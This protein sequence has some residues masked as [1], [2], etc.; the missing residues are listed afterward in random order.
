MVRGI[1]DGIII[2]GV[3]L[4]GAQWDSN[5]HCLIDCTDQRRTHRLPPLLCKL[6]PVNDLIG[7]SLVRLSSD[8]L[9]A[10]RK[11]RRQRIP[12][13]SMNVRSI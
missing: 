5:Q 3:Y 9:I 6:I 1:T 8:R 2:D 7:K 11:R 10:F 13:M 4:D 12:R